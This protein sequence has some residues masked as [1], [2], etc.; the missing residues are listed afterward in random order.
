[1]RTSMSAA[2]HAAGVATAAPVI[3]PQCPAVSTV[4]G[5]MSVPVHRK[6]EPKVISAIDGYAPGAASWPPTMAS[7]GAAV[8]AS[9]VQAVA[10]AIEKSA[11]EV[12]ESCNAAEA[13]S[14]RQRHCVR[15][16]RRSNGARSRA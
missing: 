6:E 9:D 8:R 16:Q 14:L 4:V 15:A 10:A 13:R 12:H 2:G 7:E 11:Q 3:E 1:M 5:A